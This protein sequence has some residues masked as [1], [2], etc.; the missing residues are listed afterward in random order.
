MRHS[1]W[2]NLM[3]RVMYFPYTPDSTGYVTGLPGCLFC[4]NMCAFMC[5]HF[6]HQTVLTFKNCLGVQDFFLDD[7][8]W[9]QVCEE[10]YYVVQPKGS[11]AQTCGNLGIRCLDGKSKSS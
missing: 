1:W 6:Q 9:K 4:K 2:N 11:F 7:A 5:I 3:G 10:N 8:L